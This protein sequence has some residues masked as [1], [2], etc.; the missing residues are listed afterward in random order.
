[1]GF[2]SWKTQDTDRSICNMHSHLTPFR[3]IMTDDKG[4][5]WIED[6]YD[7]YGV[8][9]GKDYYELLDEMNGGTGDRDRGIDKEFN[10]PIGKKILHPSLTECGMYYNGKKP[11][12][13]E[14]QVF[15]YYDDDDEWDEEDEDD[16]EDMW[17][18]EDD[19]DPSG[20][21]GPSSHV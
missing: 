1:M 11:K 14:F 8:F 5:Q 3:V 19:I 13:C 18:E 6:N 20:G 4:N 9:G 12:D 15:F 21:H 17:G 16:G 7:G 10:P 2:F